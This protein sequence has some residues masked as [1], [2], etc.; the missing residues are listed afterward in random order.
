MLAIIL[1]YIFATLEQST[2]NPF[3]P[4]VPI[5]PLWANIVLIPVNIGFSSVLGYCVG[6]CIARY[7]TF[8][9]EIKLPWLERIVMA[10][11]SELLLVLITLCYTLY[12]LCTPQYIQQASGILAVFVCTMAVSAHAPPEITADLKASLAGLWTFVEIFLFTTTGINLSLRAVNGPEQSMRGLSSNDVGTLIGI[13]FVGQLG[14]CVGILATGVAT[15]TTLAP[16]KRNV[17]YMLRWW[18]TTW[19]FQ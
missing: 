7:F 10:S 5:L 12:A 19:I 9:S 8:R 14:R 3:Y 4:W 11:S 13:L 15:L 17:P 18:L 6:Y 2:P 1:Y 16:H